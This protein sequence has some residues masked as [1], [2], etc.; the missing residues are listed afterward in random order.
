MVELTK[1]LLRSEIAKPDGSPIGIHD[2]HENLRLSNFHI[3]S[4]KN[5]NTLTRF[6]TVLLRFEP[7]KI[8]LSS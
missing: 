1:P 5:S 8:G 3:N 6:V 2:G 7:E 4:T